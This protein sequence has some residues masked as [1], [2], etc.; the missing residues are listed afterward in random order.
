MKIPFSNTSTYLLDSLTM[1][2]KKKNDVIRELVPFQK[3]INHF[4]RATS[5]NTIIKS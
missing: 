4:T 1:F 2:I 5:L 3:P